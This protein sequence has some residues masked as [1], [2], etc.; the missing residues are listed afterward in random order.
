MA[1]FYTNLEFVFIRLF[2]GLSHDLYRKFHVCTAF[3]QPY[4]QCSL[5]ASPQPPRT[6]P[7]PAPVPTPATIGK[8]ATTAPTAGIREYELTNQNNAPSA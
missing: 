7:C 4:A 2:A 8:A 1:D 5:G 6:Q 3:L